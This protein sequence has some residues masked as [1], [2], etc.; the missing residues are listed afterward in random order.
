M[1]LPPPPPPPPPLPRPA[2]LG[3]SDPGRRQR[4]RW[5][6]PTALTLAA[7][8]VLLVISWTVRHESLKHDGI[9]GIELTGAQSRTV[10]TSGSC[11]PRFYSDPPRVQ[12]SVY[13]PDATGFYSAIEETI[14]AIRAAGWEPEPNVDPRLKVGANMVPDRDAWYTKRVGWV[15]MRSDAIL[16][17]TATP[18]FASLMDGRGGSGFTVRLNLWVRC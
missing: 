17:L 5:A 18:G 12:L 6:R 13:V 2:G 9:V 10:S 15:P 14:A 1:S 8:G 7:G 4:R 3:Q 11:E 16:H